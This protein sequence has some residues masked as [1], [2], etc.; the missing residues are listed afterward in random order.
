MIQ[1]GMQEAAS[2]FIHVLLLSILLLAGMPAQAGLRQE[3]IPGPISGKV[4]DVIDG[5]TL[6]VRLHVWIG[7]RIETSV[8]IAGIDT[9]EI[10]GKCAKERHMA[11]ASHME[12]KRLLAD[13]DIILS[14][15]RLEKYAGRVLAHA[16]TKNGVS[17]ARH[18]IEKGLARPYKGR[19]RGSWC[20]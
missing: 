18:L 1:K 3:V 7:Q 20:L 14:R 6:S 12:L 19:K 15:I 2:A 17:I 13:G 4:L 11:K 10:N 8:R 9:P 5:D 16:S